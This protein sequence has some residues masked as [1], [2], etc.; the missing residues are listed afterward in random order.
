V[1]GYVPTLLALVAVVVQVGGVG[2]TAVSP[3][4][5]PT[6]LA[7]KFAGGVVPTAIDALGAQIVNGTGVTDTVPAT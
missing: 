5:N 2:L 6:Y 7:V 1:I 4:T 3:A